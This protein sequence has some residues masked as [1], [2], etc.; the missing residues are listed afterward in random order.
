MATNRQ[1]NKLVQRLPDL[2]VEQQQGLSYAPHHDITQWLLYTL[3]A[4][5]DLELV[6]IIRGDVRERTGGRFTQDAPVI[7]HDVIVGAVYRLTVEVDG[8][9][10]VIE[11]TGD[12][13]HPD[14]WQHDGARLKDAESDALKRCAM[15]V[16][17]GLHLWAGRNYLLDRWLPVRRDNGQAAGGQAAKPATRAA[18]R[19]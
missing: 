5:F 11:Q 7:L 6:Q 10:T 3:G 1:L 19:R 12:V 4:T 8:R 16:G 18:A 17:A 13:E 14:L 2:F 9:R 15:R